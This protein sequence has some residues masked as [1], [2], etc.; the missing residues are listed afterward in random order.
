MK[1]NMINT[2]DV[3]LTLKEVKKEKNLSLDK[4][5]SLIEQNDEYVS[6]TTLSRVFADG[7][8]EQT[9]RYEAT[10]R[11]I[12][13]ALL[14]IETI[15]T[16]D[17]VDTQAYKSILKL[18]KDLLFELERQNKE[19]KEELAVSKLK[20]HEKLSKETEKFQKSL[21]F[22]MRQIEL[23]DQRITQLLDANIQLLNQLLSCPCRKAD[24]IGADNEI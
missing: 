24:K 5:A 10:L 12:A 4:I 2:R 8:E 16:Y 22:A 3:I 11:P 1:T 7:S 13:N 20:Y 21:D 9:F 23:K 6:K 15:E 18:K 14:D 17:D 19:L